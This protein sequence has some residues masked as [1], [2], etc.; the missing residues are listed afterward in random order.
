MVEN[1]L[2]PA[3]AETEEMLPS[4]PKN[5]F[6]QMS[7]RFCLRRIWWIGGF[8]FFATTVAL[9]MAFRKPSIYQGNFYLLV[10]PITA[11]GKLSNSST[12]TRT[13]G[14]PQEALVSLDYPTNLIFLQRIYSVINYNVREWY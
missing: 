14:I 5:N 9:A 2:S 13:E 6:W 12:L 3:I 8:T 1:D 4:P 11:A 7:L 10:E